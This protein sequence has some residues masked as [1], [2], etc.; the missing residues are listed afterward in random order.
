MKLFLA[1]LLSL[2][3]S[4]FGFISQVLAAEYKCYKIPKIRIMAANDSMV[5]SVCEAADRATSFMAQYQLKPARNINV[6][7]ISQRINQN[8]YIAYGSYDRKADQI[9]MMSLDAILLSDEPPMMYGMPFDREHYIGAVAHEISHAIFQHNTSDA[10]DRWNN[11]AHEY[12]AHAVQLGVLPAQKRDEIIKTEDTQPWG[13]GDEISVTYMGFN[14]RGFAVKSYLH[15]TQLTD[16]QAFINILLNHKW[17]Y[18]S[19]P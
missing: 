8:G 14:T 5:E 13:S 1:T 15:L 7:I 12:M 18:I 11:S 4:Q 2:L 6:R 10:E 9:R 17:L 3:L 19:V 16:P